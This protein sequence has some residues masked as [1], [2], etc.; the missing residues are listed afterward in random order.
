MPAGRVALA[1]GLLLS[2][3]AVQ[4]TVLTRLP[5]PGATPDLVLLVVVA[6]ALA[7]GPTFGLAAGF[8]A[9]LATDLVPPADT[10]VGR[11]AFVLTLVGYLA[12]QA[13]GET[14]RSAFVP[15]FVVAG[16]AAAS[17]LLYAGLVALMSDTHISWLAVSEILPTAVLYDVILSAFVVPAVLVLVGKVEPDPMARR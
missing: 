1:T 4:V 12:G 5:L 7:H 2:A 15:P 8:G 13:M 17:V 16:A 11:W 6:L 14:R 9:G 10:T 3:L